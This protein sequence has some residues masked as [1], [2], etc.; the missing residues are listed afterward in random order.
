MPVRAVGTTLL[1]VRF[2]SGC[3]MLPIAC[4]AS[5][6]IATLL[7][8]GTL[9]ALLNCAPAIAGPQMS[10]KLVLAVIAVAGVGKER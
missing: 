6:I 8:A 2:R 3:S 10:Q 7:S 9:T 1:L 4:H 5:I